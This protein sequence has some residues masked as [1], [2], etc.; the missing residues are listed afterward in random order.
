MFG[1]SDDCGWEP[2]GLGII[3]YRDS[4]SCIQRGLW[5]AV[6]IMVCSTLGGTVIEV[7]LVSCSWG[8]LCL[9]PWGH[10]GVLLLSGRAFQLV[11]EGEHRWVCSCMPARQGR[12]PVL[13]YLARVRRPFVTLTAASA[14]PL[15]LGFLGELVV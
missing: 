3:E 15:L 12:G 5:S 8:S 7:I 9:D 2:E 13:S 6:T 14:W 1:L 11:N 4:L 10:S